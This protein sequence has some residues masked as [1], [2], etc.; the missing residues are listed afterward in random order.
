MKVADQTTSSGEGPQVDSDRNPVR[1]LL[2]ILGVMLLTCLFFLGADRYFPEWMP[3]GEIVVLAL[4]LLILS[5]LFSQRE[6]YQQR[7]GELAYRTAFWRFGVPGLGII[8][9]SFAHLAYI[10]GPEIPGVWWKPWLMGVGW[11]LVTGG[12]LLASRTI[13]AMGLD[14]LMMRHVYE[15]GDRPRADSG[16]YAL[17]R[18]PLYSAGMH[19]SFGLAFIHANWY[20]LLVALLI[21]LFFFGW[22]RLVEER[23]LL[24]RFPDYDE[25]RRRIPAFL[26][27]TPANEVKLWRILLGL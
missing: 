4:G 22:I 6:K 8:G 16:L 18:H 9:G 24:Q 3:D 20:A 15:R 7:Y 17:I 5:R 11:F 27:T 2:G 21:P 14:T 26:P 23:E 12:T 13:E 25:Y 1:R 19:I 10:A